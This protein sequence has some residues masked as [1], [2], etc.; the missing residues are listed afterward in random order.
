MA[1]QIR[2]GS[3]G[4][5][6][7]QGASG[8]GANAHVPALHILPDYALKAVCTAHEDTAQTSKE[9]L[10]PRSPSTISMRGCVTN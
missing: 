7:T 9:K 10:T 4:A 8:W 2:T 3:I 5:T 1:D 6:V